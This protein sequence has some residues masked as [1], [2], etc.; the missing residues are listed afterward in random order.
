MCVCVVSFCGVPNF[1]NILGS[2][3]I[4]IHDSFDDVETSSGSNQCLLKNTLTATI[5]ALI[6]KDI[7]DT[8]SYFVMRKSEVM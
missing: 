5:F 2:K 7:C 1:L 3:M 4:Q 6:S 8:V